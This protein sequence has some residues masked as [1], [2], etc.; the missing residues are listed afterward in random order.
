[1]KLTKAQRHKYYKGALN[2]L[3]Y[4]SQAICEE[5]FSVMEDSPEINFLELPYCWEIANMFP[6]LL[7]KEPVGRERGL[8]WWPKTE[9]GLSARKKVLRACIRETAPKKRK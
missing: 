1:M 6:E 4:P 8:F 3:A 5:L 9:K 7:R 2:Q